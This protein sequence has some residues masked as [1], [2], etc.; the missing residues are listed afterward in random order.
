MK[1]LLITGCGGQLG[2]EM[3]RLAKEHADFAPSF[4]DVA[5]L[6]I[7]DRRAVES[8][9]D[10]HEIDVVVNCAAYTAVDKAESQV[11]LCDRLN[12]EG[13]ANLARAIARR[14]GR[15]V[16]LSTDYVFDGTAHLPY[17]EDDR[18]CPRS[19]YG[20]TKLGGEEAVMAACP[21]SAIVRT[22]WLYSPYGNNFVK[23]MLR[24]GREREELGVVFD[25]IG[26]PTYAADLAEAI[27]RML[28]HG[29]VAGIYHFS[30]E[31]VIS[32][33]DFAKAIHR[34]VGITTCCVSPIL[35]EDYPAPA[36]RPH[37]SVLN[38]NKIKQ[39]YNLDIPY[40]E[41]SLSQ[42]IERLRADGEP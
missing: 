20:R 27:Y 37:Y 6:D 32:W 38:K 13:P 11:A 34:L 10:R 4:T 23:T 36:P 19:V 16:H 24:L 41:D 17:R 42:C 8:Y 1:N 30:N 35:T 12:R 33:Y 7:L 14:G 22:A 3:Q 18:T 31:G 21:E 2:S 26:T 15:M 40:W 39:T 5:E 9:I 25:Q 28:E 29:L